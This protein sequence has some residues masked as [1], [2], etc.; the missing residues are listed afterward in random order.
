[1]GH[2]DFFG[3]KIADL[4]MTARIMVI[5]I[6]MVPVKN[7]FEPLRMALSHLTI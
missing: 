7:G 4:S 3:I 5:C 2:I 1:M 6:A